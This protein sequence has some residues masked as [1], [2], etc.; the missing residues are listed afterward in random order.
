[1]ALT[2]NKDLDIKILNHLTDSD[3]ISVC[4]VNKKASQLCNDQKFWLNRILTKF[5]YLTIDI[6]NKYKKDRSWSDYYTKDLIKRIDN[7]FEAVEEGREDKVLIG[8]NKGINPNL[9]NKFYQTALYKAAQL[10]N[11]E[12]IKLLL[13]YGADPNIQSDT[14]S[15]ALMSAARRNSPQ[16]VKLL[17]EKGADVH[18]Q[19][20]GGGEVL[21]LTII[22]N[23]D[24]NYDVVKYLLEYGAEVNTI[25]S[26]WR[27]P[28]NRAEDL[29]RDDIVELLKE[30]GAEDL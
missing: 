6:L 27:T 28:L 10:G 20:V 24:V 22:D 30:Y 7:I 1:M 21:W 15:N 8:L 18:Q 26:V 14:G 11:F 3:L 2:G 4:K 23:K 29:G 25:D 17:L 12:M 16:I 13:D 5:P 19:T 9:K